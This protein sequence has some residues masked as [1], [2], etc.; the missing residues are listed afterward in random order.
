MKEN[1]DVKYEFAEDI[2]R[3][4]SGEEIKLQENPHDDI[5]EK[6]DNIAGVLNTKERQAAADLKKVFILVVALGII[7][8]SV[9]VLYGI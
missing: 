1:N 9:F 7:L 8:I 5:T 4:E 2:N 6:M 3:G